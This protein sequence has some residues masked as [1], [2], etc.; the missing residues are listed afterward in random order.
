MFLFSGSCLCFSSRDLVGVS[1]LGILLVF[2]FLGSCWCFS[3]LDLLGVSLPGILLV[4]LFSGGRSFLPSCWSLCL[5]LVAGF[6]LW[7]SF[8][9]TILVVSLFSGSCWCFSSLVFGLSCHFVGVSGGG[10]FV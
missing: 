3:S 9:R 5:D 6:V 8:V 2:L 1:L 7:W 4:F 10:S